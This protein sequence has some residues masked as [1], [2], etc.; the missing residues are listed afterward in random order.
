[1]IIVVTH[2]QGGFDRHSQELA[3]R[4]GAEEFHC[5]R[6]FSGAAEKKLVLQLSQLRGYV[7][8]T[9]QNFARY[10]STLKHPFIV[11]VH[12]LI[13][14][15]CDFDGETQRTLE[16]LRNDEEQIKRAE[17]IIA[18]SENTKR[19]LITR[20]GIP[21]EKITVIRNGLD[22]DI[23]R[24]A[25]GKVAR[26][27]QLFILVVG[28]ERPRKNLMRLV[29]AIARVRKDFPG[30]ALVKL[31]SEGRAAFGLKFRAHCEKLHIPVFFRGYRPDEELADFYRKASMLAF[32]SLMEGFGLPPV[33]A[34]ACGCPVV[35]SLVPALEDGESGVRIIEPL[36][37]DSIAEGILDILEGDNSERRRLGLAFAKR[38]S[39][40][41]AASKTREVYN[42]V[43]G[44]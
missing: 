25:T 26:E 34:M 35:S 40:D 1:M 13:R 27:G 17:H 3:K 14:N 41:I 43:E 28:S 20:L 44:G 36:S 18:V 22:Y 5:K 16:G 11:T 42:L 30:L 12:D 4:L 39:W 31:G 15:F 8:L 33:E 7:H 37:V 21:T 23:F 10:A 19:E 32:P 38:F 9:N 6:Y 29:E 2:E 24:P